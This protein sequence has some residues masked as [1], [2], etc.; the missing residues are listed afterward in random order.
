VRE[1]TKK[2]KFASAFMHKEMVHLN[3]QLLYECNFRCRIC[4][5]W[6]PRF[7]D[8][9]KLSVADIEVMAKKLPGPMIVSIGGGEPM[10]HPDLTDIIR[11][12]ARDNFPV[13]ICNGWYVTPENARAVFEAGL[14]EISISVDYADPARHDKQRGMKGAFDRAVKALETL[15]ENRVHP[16]QRVHMISVVMN[17]NVDE[18]EPLI[19][20][21]KEIGVT[22]LVTHHS[23]NRGKKP[24]RDSADRDVSAHLLELRKKHGNFVACRGFLERFT[25][26]QRSPD[27]IKPCYAGKNL[28]NID[29]QGNVT[30]CIDRLD[31]VAGNILRDDYE[32]IASKL[33]AFQAADDCGDCWTSCRG[34]FE[35]L[36]YGKNR[37]RNLVDSYQVTRKLPLVQ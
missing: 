9:P 23:S 20:L 27:G 22:Y 8:M 37:I 33:L 14:H 11:V 36:M 10:M 21:A 34:W 3:L 16:H 19:L 17:D 5:F 4:D 6:K 12:L 31:Q 32:D 2:I 7:K 15:H 13:M 28:F 24:R 25:E 1:M 29:C 30:R 35:T 26:A 18:I